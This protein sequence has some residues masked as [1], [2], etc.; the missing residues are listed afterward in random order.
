[1]SKLGWDGT[2]CFF[3]ILLDYYWVI[4]FWGIEKRFVFWTSLEVRWIRTLNKSTLGWTA[5]WYS[6]LKGDLPRT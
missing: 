5:F 4:I 2:V 6:G 3:F 1:M